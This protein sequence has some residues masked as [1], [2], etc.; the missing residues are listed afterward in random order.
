MSCNE[1]EATIPVSIKCWRIKGMID[2]NFPLPSHT[3][4]CSRMRRQ[5]GLDEIP[6][7]LVLKQELN[8]YMHNELVIHGH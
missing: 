8:W 7:C 3:V 4:R 6:T 5:I 1:F 2:L